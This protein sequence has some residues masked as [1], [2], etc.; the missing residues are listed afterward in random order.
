MRVGIISLGNLK[1]KYTRHSFT[2]S[3]LDVQN[4]FIKKR[5]TTKSR[6]RWSVLVNGQ[7]YFFK[8]ESWDLAVGRGHSRRT[9]SALRAQAFR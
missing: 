2:M 5:T 3:L 1:P 9:R 8:F 4:S 6:L 7:T